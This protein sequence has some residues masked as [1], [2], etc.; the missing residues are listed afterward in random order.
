MFQDRREAGERLG[1]RLLERGLGGAV[2]LGI[3]RGGVVVADAVARRIGGQLG[4]I[5]ACELRAPGQAELTMGAVASDG[6]CWVEPRVMRV[7][8]V[9]Q[10]Y[11]EA[12]RHS[13]CEE[14]RRLEVLF[15]GRLA[16]S[17]RMV[18]VVDE[19]VMTGATAMA[20]LRAVRA[21]GCAGVVFAAPVASAEAA[22][23]LRREADRVEL[24]VEDPRFV[25]ARDYY[26]D[27]EEVEDAEVMDILEKSRRLAA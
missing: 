26:E 20:V 15:D 5:V 22:E 8:G 19:G 7:L 25:A 4:V 16:V 23:R 1:E 6:S 12:E 14:A 3:P 11:L 2:V 27:F 17:G 10:A 24:L 13:Q 9:D 18:V 21:G